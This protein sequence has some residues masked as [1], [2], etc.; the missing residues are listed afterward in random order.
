MPEKD[1]EARAVRAPAA[2]LSFLDQVLISAAR[3]LAGLLLI[4]S[5][6]AEEYGLYMLLFSIIL[7][8]ISVQNALITTP[9]TVLAPTMAQDEQ[10]RFVRALA[11]G[12]YLIWLPLLIFI[13]AGMLFFQRPESMI[14]PGLALVL[15][16]A[17][18][19][20]LAREFFRRAF[21][22]IFRPGQVV[23][24]DFIDAAIL[25]SALILLARGEG[26]MSA[27]AVI[28]LTGLAAMFAG[29]FAA[30]EFFGFFRVPSGD[31]FAALRRCWP[32][33]RWSLLGVI[34]TWLQMQGFLF[35]LDFL[36]SREDVGHVSA[37]RMLLV[38]VMMLNTALISLYKPRSAGVLAEKGPAAAARLLMRMTMMAGLGALLWFV[39]VFFGKEVLQNVVLKTRIPG[40]EGLLALWAG[41]FVLQIIRT[42]MSA[43]LQIRHQ[44]ERLFYVGAV[45]ASASLA[46]GWWLIPQHGAA[47]SLYGVLIGEG[48][49]LIGLL[50]MI[51]GAQTSSQRAGEAQKAP[52]P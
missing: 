6:S 12:Q 7:L 13:P 28:A 52:V 21:F 36:Q 17:L 15:A 11:K 18:F 4:R 26:L 39:L 51:R 27:Q 48:V 23:R 30:R 34:V 43:F 19:F 25:I 41:V 44:F 31:V 46:A 29:V 35:L 50:L 2:L 9:M 45:A 22:V 10:S 8:A 3:F 40:Y 16:A 14:T 20:I 47:G 1:R 24:T 49:F 37:V 42:A 33:G 5:A 38:P 32:F